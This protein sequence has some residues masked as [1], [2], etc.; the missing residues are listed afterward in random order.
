[1][2]W[3]SGIFVFAKADMGLHEYIQQSA[4]FIRSLAVINFMEIKI[5]SVMVGSHFTF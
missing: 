5:L 1:V 4:T 3:E 2:S